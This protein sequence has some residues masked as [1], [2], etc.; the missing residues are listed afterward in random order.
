MVQTA[1]NSTQRHKIEQTQEYRLGT[2][3]NITLF[4]SLYRV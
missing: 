4:G 2:V 3:S 1:Q